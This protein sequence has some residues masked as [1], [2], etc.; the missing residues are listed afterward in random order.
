MSQDLRETVTRFLDELDGPKGEEA[1]CS[2]TSLPSE[3]LR[4]VAEAYH[5]ETDGRR[6]QSLIHALW[7][8][9]DAAA[10]ATLSAALRDPDDRVW[11]EAL[12]GIVTVGGPAGLRVLEEAR[13]DL[14]G[15]RMSS[16][17]RE[18]IDEA[19]EQLEEAMTRENGSSGEPEKRQREPVGRVQNRG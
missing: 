16:T 2:L 10:L 4:F 17:K 14:P 13:S 6:R 15:D 7:Q 11:K 19:I 18:W 1:L 9:R 12:D 8:F 3:A 5:R